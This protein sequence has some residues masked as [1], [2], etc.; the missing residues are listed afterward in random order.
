MEDSKMTDQQLLDTP[1]V[2]LSA[3]LYYRKYKLQ[4]AK[5]GM[6]GSSV[7]M[8]PAD[9][10]Y[11]LFVYYSKAKKRLLSGNSLVKVIR[12]EGTKC[13]NERAKLLAEEFAIKFEEEGHSW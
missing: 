4:Q 13:S 11:D 1:D 6:K 3:G 9:A 7:N 2:E 5:S 10:L 8:V 12:A